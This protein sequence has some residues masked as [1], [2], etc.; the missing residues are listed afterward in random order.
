MTTDIESPV[1]PVAVVP[2]L[3]TRDVAVHYGGIRAVDGVSIAL[4]PRQIYGL[5]GPN[6]SGKSTLL[7]AITRLVPLTRGELFLGGEAYNRAAAT[8]LAQRG[9]ARTF[10]TVRLLPDLTVVE[11]VQLGADLRGRAV[12]ARRWWGRPRPSESVLVALERTG[13]ADR[14]HLYPGELSYGMQ[15]RVEIA[16]ALALDPRLL[17]LDEPTAGMNTG[18]RVEIS[19]LLDRLRSEGLTQLLV[20]HDVQMMVDTCDHLFAMNFGVLIGEGRPGDVVGLPQVQEAYL[21]R[22][23]GEDA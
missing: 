22:S 23:V 9:V 17:L 2:V 5:L 14:Q 7:A 10:Q 21:G 12:G 3:E 20:E 18:E 1:P 15:R 8:T 4:P 19:G 16:R 13:L 11:N 6:G